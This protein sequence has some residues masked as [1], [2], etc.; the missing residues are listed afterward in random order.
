MAPSRT[1]ARDLERYPFIGHHRIC[2]I[3][4]GIDL[5]RYDPDRIDRVRA[6]RELRERLG[7]APGAPVVCFVSRLSQRKRPD[8]FLDACERLARYSDAIRH[9]ETAQQYSSDASNIF[10]YRETLARLKRLRA[11]A[12]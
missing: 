11:E 10:R 2:P 7:A 5:D 9:L 6:R 1:I 12:E 8:L 4:H 3:V